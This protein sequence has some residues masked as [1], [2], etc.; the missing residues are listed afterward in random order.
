MK[1]AVVGIVAAC[2]WHAT[3]VN[4][5]FRRIR[6][7]PARHARAVATLN[8]DDLFGFQ[9][10]NNN[11][12]AAEITVQGVNFTAQLD[13]G[14]SDFWVDS[15]LAP[16]NASFANATNTG[17][18]ATS[19]Y[20]DST[21]AGGPIL[22]VDVTFGNF[23]I[24]GQA[25]IDAV[26]TNATE[27]TG[28]SGLIGLGAPA[29]TSSSVIQSKGSDPGLNE[30]PLMNNLYDTHPDV[31]NY[32]TF[33]LSRAPLHDDTAGGILTVGEVSDNWPEIQDAEQLP[34]LLDNAWATVIDGFVVNGH[35]VI[36]TSKILPD[37]PPQM[38]TLFDTGTARALAPPE[39]VD[40]LYKDLPGAE[41][42]GCCQYTLPCDTLTNISV[43]I[44]GRMFPIHPI[45]AVIIP[46]VGEEP[47]AD[48]DATIC[49]SAFSYTSPGY[50]DA[51]LGDTFHRNAYVLYYF[52]NWTRQDDVP[53]YIQLL[54]TTNASAAAE[55]FAALNTARITA[56][57]AAQQASPLQNATRRSFTVLPTFL[58][59]F[60]IMIAHG[61]LTL[62][63]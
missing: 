56:R 8:A 21:C 49:I 45:D 33:L 53:P 16:N 24:S 1:A 6:T 28:I 2:A 31:D 10:L 42:D 57:K 17:L 59:T 37:S 50:V 32:M 44:G 30:S 36:D 5:P 13:T 38:L 46:E 39:V 48:A 55:E 22:V 63:L 18:T 15:S 35:A 23:T 51:I 27:G 3:A 58:S 9:N 52:G 25:M 41:F 47:R 34:V 61:L 62:L 20:L 26:G 11:V 14:S 7:F 4:I 19:C 60:S 29:S 54:S 12:Y 43:I 40:A